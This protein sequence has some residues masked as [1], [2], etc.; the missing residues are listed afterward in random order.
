MSNRELEIFDLV[1]FRLFKKGDYLKLNESQQE[2]VKLE[3][4]RHKLINK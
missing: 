2:Q 3:V 1:T 4:L